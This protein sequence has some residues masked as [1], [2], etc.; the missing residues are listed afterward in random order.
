MRCCDVEKMLDEMR[1]AVDSHRS[2]VTDH[3]RECAKCQELYAQYEG[4][5]YCLT[6]LPPPQPPADLVP[7]IIDHI[8]TAVKATVP[9]N[10]VKLKS[11]IGALY[12]AF[13]ASPGGLTRS[14]EAIRER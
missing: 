1:D 3:L 6:C 7:K 11:P 5:A 2:A 10:V 13:R 9:D 8:R 4:V 12:V 14:L